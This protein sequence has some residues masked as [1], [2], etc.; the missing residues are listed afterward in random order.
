M[1]GRERVHTP[2]L[3]VAYSQVVT[4]AGP[5]V[6]LQ[7]GG[8]H[9][10]GAGLPGVLLASLGVPGGGDAR[11]DKNRFHLAAGKAPWTVFGGP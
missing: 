10:T 5:E 9:E 7:E 6:P 11:G 2:H 8:N 4:D 3:G 1:R